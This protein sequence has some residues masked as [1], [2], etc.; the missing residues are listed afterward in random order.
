MMEGHLENQEDFK[1]ARDQSPIHDD[2]QQPRG[3]DHTSSRQT[4]FPPRDA[5]GQSPGLS[6]TS[7]AENTSDAGV[8]VSSLPTPNKQGEELKDDDNQNTS[9]WEEVVQRCRRMPTVRANVLLLGGFT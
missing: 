3:S 2:Y 5:E 6:I 9:G 7:H 4:E 8:C 1:Y